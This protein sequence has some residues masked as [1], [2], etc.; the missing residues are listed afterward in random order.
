[1]FIVLTSIHFNVL[2]PISD[3][4]FIFSNL[5]PRSSRNELFE[6]DESEFLEEVRRAIRI[7]GRDSIVDA[8]LFDTGE[9]EGLNRR[10]SGIW[11][12]GEES[13]TDSS[14]DEFGER[15]SSSDEDVGEEDSIDNEAE[16]N[17][18]RVKLHDPVVH[19]HFH[20]PPF[21]DISYTFYG[22]PCG[23]CDCDDF[24]FACCLQENNFQFLKDCYY[25]I[26]FDVQQNLAETSVDVERRRPNNEL[27]KY[28]Y[29]KL[30]VSLDFGVLEVGER[31][32]LPNCAV[33]KIRQLYPSETG[34][35]MG[36]KES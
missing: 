15:G 35:Y 11:N 26:D 13:E 3:Q 33:A 4:N 27:R 21:D 19:D 23:V 24:C 28:F 17:N 36:F 14:E 1:M 22:V 29:K 16:V 5:Y 2:S 12:S 7:N 31:R 34:Y 32:R 20:C 6:V 10:H 30:F 8:I 9:D 18:D 25:S